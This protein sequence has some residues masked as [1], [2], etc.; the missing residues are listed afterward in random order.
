MKEAAYKIVA[1]DKD[2]TASI[3]DRLLSL[4]VSDS[5]GEESDTV[6]I[7]L[8]NREE[9]IALPPTG[10]S[11]DIYIG[12]RDELIFKGT[13]EVD[14]IEVPFPEELMVL[15]GKSAKMKQSYKSPKQATY[16]EVTFGELAS[17]IAEQHGYE[18]AISDSVKS[19]HFPHIDQVNESDMNL[20]NRLARAHGA[21]GKVIANRLVITPKGE[22]KTVTGKELP[23][24]HLS[25]S[26]ES[27]GRV[28]IQERS[29]FK[30]VKS[31]WFLEAE[32]RTVI[33]T[34]G[35]GEP[36]F[37]IAKTYSNQE[38]AI[39]AANAKLKKLLNASASLS[40]STTLIAELQTESPLVI[41]NHRPGVNGE[42]VI[43]RVMHTISSNSVSET[44][45]SAV[46][47]R[48]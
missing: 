29:N 35:D 12:L 37:S 41:S 11:L 45:L 17:L 26:S 33:E 25:D 28:T 5:S 14:E 46:R 23:I 31:R 20:I 9:V 15:H 18:L 19:I 47:K 13:F 1:N 40:L 38:E 7:E 27:K 6:T 44:S 16:D 8:D 36:S 34:V 43:E 21:I 22:S 32:Q 48:S 10:A 3:M 24:V 2:I 30:S 4:Q 42:W 39:S